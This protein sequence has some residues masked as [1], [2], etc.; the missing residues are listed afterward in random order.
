MC[1]FVSVG[2]CIFPGGQT[3]GRIQKKVHRRCQK[4]KEEVRQADGEVLSMSGTLFEY[5]NQKAKF[6][7]GGKMFSRQKATIYFN[8]STGEFKL[9]LTRD[10]EFCVVGHRKAML[11]YVSLLFYFRQQHGR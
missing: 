4:R 9:A 10:I 11:L 7:S 8:L 2:Q 5:D 1:L 6:T 3:F